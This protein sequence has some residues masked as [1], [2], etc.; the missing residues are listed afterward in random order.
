MKD[1]KKFTKSA[2]KTRKCSNFRCKLAS[3][4]LWPE[5]LHIQ[6]RGCVTPRKIFPCAYLASFETIVI[7]ALHLW[8]IQNWIARRRIV[9]S[10][11]RVHLPVV[12]WSNSVS[13][14][15]LHASNYKLSRAVGNEIFKVGIGLFESRL[16]DKSR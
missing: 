11:S 7:K 10:A 6:A 15:V 9:L 3:D 1:F 5:T 14:M 13:K 12:S 2:F 8:L 4:S 16:G